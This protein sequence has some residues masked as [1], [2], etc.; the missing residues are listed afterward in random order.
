M[1]KKVKD[2]TVPATAEESTGAAEATETVVVNIEDIE[3]APEAVKSPGR[4][5][6]LTE[7]RRLMSA[8]RV[9]KIWRCPYKG[10]WF[11]NEERAKSHAVKHDV[12]MQTFE[13]ED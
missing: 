4:E 2:E 13:W 5:Q 8:N 9:R 3:A 6:F 12:A 11:T 1:A 7:A 10:Y